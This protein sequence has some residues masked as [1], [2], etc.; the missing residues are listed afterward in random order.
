MNEL[1]NYNIDEIKSQVVELKNWGSYIVLDNFLKK[2]IFDTLVKE[3]NTLKPQI[4]NACDRQSCSIG[5]KGINYTLGGGGSTK[6]A[7]KPLMD[8]SK[9]WDM[10]L[11]QIYSEQSKKYF[12]DIFSNTNIYKDIVKPYSGKVGCKLSFQT[13]DYGW[14]IHQDGLKKILSFLIYLGNEG[15]DSKSKGSTDLWVVGDKKQPYSKDKLSLDNRL[16][17]GIFSNKEASL[18]KSE[19]DYIYNFKSVEFVPNRILGFVRTNNSY[20][21]IPP[22]IL[23]ENITRDCFQIN[24]WH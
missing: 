5:G 9:N 23:P 7:F 19:A 2:E 4:L 18:K 17:G 14:V 12:H 20:H 1:I 16:R 13:K 24:I 21:S 15:W 8:I 6:S 10:F 22:R 3:I 11:Q